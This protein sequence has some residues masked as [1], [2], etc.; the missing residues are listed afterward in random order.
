M[1]PEDVLTDNETVVHV[2]T[3]SSVSLPQAASA[4]LPAQTQRPA[5]TLP[6]ERRWR[7]VKED[8]PPQFSRR[9][10]EFSTFLCEAVATIMGVLLSRHDI[11][12][13]VLMV[14]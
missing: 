11:N 1:E 6:G 9:H 10:R 3:L 8:L 4:Q 13:Y 5:R 14:L 2:S 12:R 7:S